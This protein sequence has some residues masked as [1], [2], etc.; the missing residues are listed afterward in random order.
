MKFSLFPGGGKKADTAKAA[1]KESPKAAASTPKARV[2]AKNASSSDG[3]RLII[4]GF[5]FISSA[6]VGAI[7]LLYLTVNAQSAK[8]SELRDMKQDLVL[9]RTEKDLV[10]I[11]AEQLELEVGR[12]IDLDKVVTAS[13]KVHGADEAGRKQGSMWI[14]RKTLSCMVTLGALNGV[15]KGSEL[16]VYDGENKL[17]T[18]KIVS[19]LD[20][21][22]Y[23]EPVNREL[24][25]FTKD[26]YA[27][28]TE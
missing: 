14:N 4:T 7:F 5:V 10:K 22:S 21:V 16:G 20:V 11:R 13:Q 27:V 3:K 6:F 12:V 17:G 25:E 28:K 19:T 1:P 23:A 15:T 2:I 9:A 8:E 18:V 24:K 26:Y